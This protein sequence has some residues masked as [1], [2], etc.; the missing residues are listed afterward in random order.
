MKH[1]KKYSERQLPSLR[2]DMFTQDKPG[3][4]CCRCQY[5]SPVLTSSVPL[6]TGS[7]TS[8]L[9]RRLQELFISI[10]PTHHLQLSAEMHFTAFLTSQVL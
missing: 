9:P 4:L 1:S 5:H 3:G 7:L 8:L 10:F 2:E 6:H